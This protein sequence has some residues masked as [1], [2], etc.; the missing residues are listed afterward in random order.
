V[1]SWG[2]T[3]DID[4]VDVLEM[5]S[6]SLDVVVEAPSCDDVVIFT[7]TDVEGSS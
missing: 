1:L 7:L 6:V 4:I 5:V 2:S 3:V